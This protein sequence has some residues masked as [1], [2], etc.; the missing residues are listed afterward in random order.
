[1]TVPGNAGWPQLEIAV[2]GAAG[3][4]IAQNAGADRVELCS[5]L[6]LGGVTP[7]QG[8]VE[9]VLAATGG[10]FGIHVLV[11]PRPGNFVYDADDVATAEAEAAALA[12][13]G[14]HGIVLGALDEARGID[15][16]TTQRLINAARSI[17]PQMGITFHRALDHTLDPLGAIEVLA[18]LEIDRVLTSGQAA[19]AGDGVEMLSA[20][21][22][23][24]RGRLEVMAG[25]GVTIAG[26]KALLCTTGVAAA[27]LS[28]KV[29]GRRAASASVSLGSA[30]TLD[31]DAYCVTDEGIVREAVNVVRTQRTLG[32]R[33]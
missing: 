9:R 14:V 32:T 28:A 20:M 30:A 6:E 33:R 27:H 21:V 2:T 26:L 25:G 12:L 10:G 22:A 31:P 13:Q 15:I 29:P 18:A 17:N 23:T 5:A 19:A 24:A 1:M 11:R 7:S 4:R 8:T 16:P 3:A